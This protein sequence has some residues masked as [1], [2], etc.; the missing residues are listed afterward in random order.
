MSR[1]NAPAAPT[2]VHAYFDNVQVWLRRPADPTALRFLRKHCGKGGIYVDNRPA[3]FGQGYKQRLELKQP[4][5]TALQWLAER[6]D[7]LINRVEI[8]LDYIFDSRID[9]DRA[10][11]FFHHH[12]IRRWHSNKQ[13]I[14]LCRT[15]NDG[16]GRGRYSSE[17]VY[18]IEEATTRYDSG[19]RSRNGT[20]VYLENHSRVTGEL[21]CLHLEWRANGLRAVQG[22]GIKSAV[23][24]L[25]FDHHEFWKKRLL[26]TD[27]DIERL[28]RLF[29]NRAQGSK[30]RSTAFKPDRGR[31]INM[32][33]RWGHAIKNSVGSLQELLHSYRSLVRLE[34]ALRPI[35][36][37]GWLPPSVRRVE[38]E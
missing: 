29:R 11:E 23:D 26:L 5:A 22:A 10:Q 30:S 33:R 3:P 38:R 15:S 25:E 9:R 21:F 24:L 36:N 17:R 6:D 34:R 20:T 32:D 8:T 1:L 28:G 37:S 13:P 35:S 14:W 18:E 12:R 2:A 4:L 31:Q 27:L 7:V 16:N 19:R